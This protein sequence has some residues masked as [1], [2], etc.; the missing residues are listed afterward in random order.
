VRTQSVTSLLGMQGSA[1]TR[2]ELTRREGRSS[3]IVHL[4]RACRGYQC[5]AVP[6]RKKEKSF[7][8]S[9]DARTLGNPQ[10]SPP[11]SLRGRDK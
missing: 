9:F 2:I 3:V 5:A 7:L 1:I 11:S 8:D 10:A 6:E 4:G